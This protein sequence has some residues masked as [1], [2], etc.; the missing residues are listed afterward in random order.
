[1][2][3]YQNGRFSQNGV[4]F[5]LPRE[6]FFDSYDDEVVLENGI[7]VLSGNQDCYLQ[8]AIHKNRK[9]TSEDLEQLWR[10][11]SATAL[12]GLE[13]IQH[14]GL[15]GHRAYYAYSDGMQ[16]FEMRLAL[17]EDMQ[18]SITIETDGKDTVELVKSE[19]I[20][21]LLREIQAE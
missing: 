7:R 1:M 13:E 16:F 4:S 12:S 6:F 9:S 3:H 20:Q 21:N 11:G 19:E 15:T 17:P 14:N 10:S 2:L 18:F 8:F 5:A